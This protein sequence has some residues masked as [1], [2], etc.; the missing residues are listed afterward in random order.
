MAK[1]YTAFSHKGKAYLALHAEAGRTAEAATLYVVPGAPP[2]YLVGPSNAADMEEA[3][4]TPLITIIPHAAASWKARAARR[5][6]CGC[7]FCWEG[8]DGPAEG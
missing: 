6:A 7:G 1:Y 2:M 3:G 5:E 4:A 8:D